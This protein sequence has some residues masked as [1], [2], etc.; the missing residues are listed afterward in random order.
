MAKNI[1][2]KGAGEGIAAEDSGRGVEEDALLRREH[3]QHL[4]GGAES[5]IE[6]VGGDEDSLL[7]L[8]GDALQEVE[9]LYTRGQVKVRGRFVAP[10]P[11]SASLKAVNHV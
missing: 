1:H 3:E 10:V 5:Q 6:F 9:R 8:V 4:I 11:S 2:A 7:L